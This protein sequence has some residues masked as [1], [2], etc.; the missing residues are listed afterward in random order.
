MTAQPI[1]LVAAGDPDAAVRSALDQAGFPMQIA[2]LD[3]AALTG[4]LAV[5]DSAGAAEAAAAFCR[6]WRS[7]SDGQHAPLVWLA[8]G[9]GP[10]ARAAGWRAG[11]D[12][13]LVR[14]LALGEL[15]AQVTRLVQW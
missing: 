2:A 5:V 11:A 13:V 14:P 6:R 1:L 3:T 12:A 7:Q 9:P 15:A 8:D 10:E 4:R